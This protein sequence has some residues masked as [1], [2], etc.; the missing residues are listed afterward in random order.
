MWSFVCFFCC[1]FSLFLLLLQLAY[2]GAFARPFAN[3]HLGCGRERGSEWGHLRYYFIG[4]VLA[5]HV[6][7]GQT[8]TGVPLEPCVQL[9][10]VFVED[11]DC[12][13]VEDH[14]LNLLSGHDSIALVGRCLAVALGGWALASVARC[15][16]G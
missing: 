10:D 2:L 1:L 3:T 14:A 13:A 8:A 11:D 9:E 16:G 6:Q 12:L 5:N 4:R 7:D 15:H